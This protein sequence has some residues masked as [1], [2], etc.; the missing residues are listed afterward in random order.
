[1]NQNSTITV[2][3]DQNQSCISIPSH[4]AV[5]YILWTSNFIHY[6]YFVSLSRR[7]QL[8]RLCLWTDPPEASSRQ[9]TDWPQKSLLLQ[10]VFISL[11]IFLSLSSYV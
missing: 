7:P 11:F 9:K 2:Q 8:H 4:V 3:M 1:M 6:H 10:M 5:S